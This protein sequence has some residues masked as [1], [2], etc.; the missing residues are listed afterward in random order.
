MA[1]W[2]TGKWQMNGFPVQTSGNTD[3]AVS[4]HQSENLN[5]VPIKFLGVVHSACSFNATMCE[6]LP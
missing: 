2:Q 1:L 6:P 4:P 3:R 5:S